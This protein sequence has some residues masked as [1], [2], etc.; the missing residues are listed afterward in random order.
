MSEK[1]RGIVYAAISDPIMEQRITIQRY[2]LPS[3]DVLDARLFALEHEI[4]RRV[5]K[6]L[7]LD[8]HT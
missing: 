1:K 3:S 2:G 6:V 7:N 4:W 8:G 5:H